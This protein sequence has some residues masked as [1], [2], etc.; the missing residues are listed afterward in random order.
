MV[1]DM[2]EMK[3]SGV[4]IIGSIPQSWSISR[5]KY[6]LREPMKYGATE[7]GEDFDPSLYRYIRITDIT[8]EGAL[9]EDGKLSL[10]PQQAFGYVLKDKTVLF[11]RSGGTVGKSFLYKTSYGPSAFA[12]YLISGVAD[13][14]KM[15]PEWLMYYTNSSAYWEWVSQIFTQA[16]IQNIGADKYSN[17]PIAIAPISEQRIIVAFLDSKCAEIDALS[18]DIQSEIDTLEAYKR[19]KVFDTVTHG[20][21]HTDFVQTDS[22]VWSTIPAGWKLVDIKYIFEIVK[23]IAGKEGFDVIAITQQGLK[24]KDITS[25]EGQLASDYSGY[26]FVY[27][28]DYAMNHMDLLTGWVDLSDKFGVT[29]PDYRVFRLRYPDAYDHKY[30]KY[31]MQCCYMNRIFYSLGQGV[32]NLGRWRLQTSAFNN[33]KVPVPPYEKQVKIGEY[34]DAEISEINGIIAQKQEQIAVLAEYKKSII[35]EY[36]TGKKEVPVT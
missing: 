32:S 2:R 35:Y 15:L 3:D 8:S 16:T 25:N 5:L 31:I 14:R 23:R 19:S 30:Y 17:M 1:A 7:T 18:A 12:G 11:A 26:Q 22:D 4:E 29:S 24:Y 33:F 28:G 6:N 21:D 36:V 20:I 34:L 9:K 27:P 13:E 10:T